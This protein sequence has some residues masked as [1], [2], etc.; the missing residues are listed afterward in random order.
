MILG[1]FRRKVVNVEKENPNS[2][3]FYKTIVD[4]FSTPILILK[5]DKE[6]NGTT[7]VYFNS[8]FTELTK[9]YI[10]FPKSN[11]KIGDSYELFSVSP[12][13]KIRRM[14]SVLDGLEKVFQKKNGQSQ[15][16]NV[17]LIK[18]PEEGTEVDA[19][20][21]ENFDNQ[22]PH[23]LTLVKLA[24]DT[25]AIIYQS[26]KDKDENGFS[27]NLNNLV[28]LSSASQGAF[29]LK[30][31]V[32]NYINVQFLEMLGYE[33]PN[34][35]VNNHIDQFILEDDC[36]EFKLHLENLKESESVETTCRFKKKDGSFIW[37]RLNCG[38]FNLG[39]KL[40][41]SVVVNAVDI[42]EQKKTELALFQTH[43][44]ASIGEL[45]SGVAHEINNPLFGIMNYAGL[46]K[47]AI[48][49]GETITKDSD[50]YEFITGIIEESERIAGIT[51]NLSEFSRNAEDRDYAETDLEDLIDKVGNVLRHQLKRAHAKF[52]KDIQA[53]F[54]KNLFLQRHRI[55]TALFNMVLNS[56]QALNLVKDR[57]HLI[58]ISLKLE[59]KNSSSCAVIKIWDNGIG[60]EDDKLVKVFDPFYTTNRSQKTGLGLHTVFQIIKDHSGDIRVSSKFGQWTEFTIRIPIISQ[61]P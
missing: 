4:S 32:V 7:V 21:L 16:I 51:N 55:R 50:E 17:S 33:K 22:V 58:K 52:E 25:I 45:A 47:D 35:V 31:E 28:N 8:S 54:P 59:G 27:S 3:T 42:S 11:I 49:E 43:R 10:L 9:A 15:K 24:E 6:K 26:M 1:N 13:T 60:I 23:Q 5:I 30:D 12:G 57:D 20:T 2:D 18:Q 56:T 38:V 53:S 29:V 41:T 36:R 34:D 61:K 40:G 19:T 14:S 37:L 46:I 44:M 39:G 48:D